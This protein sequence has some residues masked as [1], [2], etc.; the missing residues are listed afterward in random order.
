MIP[1]YLP[2]AGG[3]PIP[4][5][6]CRWQET[7]RVHQFTMVLGIAI[8]LHTLPVEAQES[9]SFVLGFKAIHEL[10][11]EVV[12]MCLED[13]RTNPE[14]GD[15]FQQTTNGLLVWHRAD[16][17][18]AFTDGSTTWVNGPNGL[19][20]RPSGERFPWEVGPPA[21]GS[22]IE[23]LVLLGP[24][25]PGPQRQ[26]QS[27]ERPY[28]ATIT[29]LDQQGHEVTQVR[30]AVDGTFRLQL[31]PGTYTLRPRSPGLLPRASEQEVTVEPGR[32]TRVD[33]R[34]DTGIR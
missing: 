15:A 22:G 11:P 27:C 9:C 25:C 18:T 29:V 28:E 33:I 34:Y 16:N 19:Q 12:G 23:G 26:G 31:A 6:A 2:R 8:L 13:Q 10:I 30:T 4:G 21:T 5:S 24:T 20:A 7:Y 32:L 17:V 1:G 14:N 3:I